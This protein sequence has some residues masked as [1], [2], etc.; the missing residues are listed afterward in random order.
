MNG[1]AIYEIPVCK[2]STYKGVKKKA[3]EVY[4]CKHHVKK[5]PISQSGTEYHIVKP[6]EIKRCIMRDGEVTL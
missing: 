4:D 3:C 6:D 1:Y 5:V 2:H